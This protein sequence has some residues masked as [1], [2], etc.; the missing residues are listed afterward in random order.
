MNKKH[1]MAW[2]FAPALLLGAG[3][4]DSDS[5]YDPGIEFSKTGEVTLI[6][7]IRN[8]TT[9]ASLVNTGE[10]RWL[11]GDALSVVCTD[12]SAVTFTL[13]GTGGTR[14]AFFKGTIPD[15]REMGPY[16]LYPTTTSISGSDVRVT[17]PAE[18]VM[19]G[20]GVASRLMY[21]VW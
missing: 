20:E 13:D 10:A 11:A 21:K 18:K 19:S 6:A 1:L 15:G 3:C 17:L 9:R 12:G 2:Y 14:R 8:C 4:S 7:S 16:A 5:G